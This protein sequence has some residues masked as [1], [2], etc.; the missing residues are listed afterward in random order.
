MAGRRTK[1]W[2]PPGRAHTLTSCYCTGSSSPRRSRRHPPLAFWAAERNRFFPYL[3]LLKSQVKESL[4]PSRISPDATGQ[5]PRLQLQYR[6]NSYHVRDRLTASFHSALTPIR[7]EH[8]AQFETLRST[9]ATIRAKNYDP[10][11]SGWRFGFHCENLIWT[12]T[13]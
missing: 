2:K 5:V 10:L 13:G 6:Q 4:L 1:T 3:S 11:L 12:G 8:L 7:G 9:N